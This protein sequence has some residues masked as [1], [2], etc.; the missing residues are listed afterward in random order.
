MSS[1]SWRAGLATALP[2]ALL[3]AGC[4]QWGQPQER[5]PKDAD[6]VATLSV[7][8]VSAA[9][10]ELYAK[11]LSP[12]FEIDAE[13]ALRLVGASTRQ[14]EDT[15]VRATQATFRIAPEVLTSQRSTM[16]SVD[17]TGAVSASSAASSAAGPGDLSKVSGPTFAATTLPAAIAASAPSGMNPMLQYQLANAL[18]QEVRLLNDYVSRAPRAK[19]HAP[20]VVRLQVNVLQKGRDTPYDAVTDI[21]F[22]LPDDTNCEGKNKTVRAVPLLV[23]DNV[24][25]GTAAFASHRASAVGLALAGLRGNV[26][27]GADVSRSTQQLLRSLGNQFNSVLNVGQT[28]RTNDDAKADSIRVKVG[29]MEKGLN[30]HELV[31]RSYMV[32]VLLLVPRCAQPASLRVSRLSLARDSVMANA[33]ALPAQQAASAGFAAAVKAVKD[34]SEEERSQRFATIQFSSTTFFE[35]ARTA[36]RLAA[37][38]PVSSG[39]TQ[40]CAKCKEAESTGTDRSKA[41]VDLWTWPKPRFPGPQLTRVELVEVGSGKPG[42]F[43]GKVTLRGG[44]GLV[45]NYFDRACLVAGDAMLPA[46]N[47]KACDREEAL[48][49][50]GLEVVNGRNGIQASFGPI[51]ELGSASFKATPEVVA[52]SGKGLRRFCYDYIGDLEDAKGP[53][54]S[55]CVVLQPPPPAGKA[56]SEPAF[57]AK[58]RTDDSRLIASRPGTATLTLA[59][60]WPKKKGAEPDAV[61]IQL[62]GAGVAGLRV[63]GGA[64]ACARLADVLVVTNTCLLAVDLINAAPGRLITLSAKALKADKEQSLELNPSRIEVMLRTPEPAVLLPLGKP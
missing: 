51:L 38:Q 45:S 26:G 20:Y 3:L 63:L 10:F 36:E 56:S 32:T 1:L 64:A 62:G 57:T 18:I 23:N 27:V 22:S 28:P 50:D 15:F 47:G 40:D 6:D 7:A 11:D 30:Q 35:H 34:A 39:P 58:V 41:Q 19:H 60:E 8:V 48:L 31:S 44:D 14:I 37:R 2:L 59:V 12:N 43:S 49:A 24:D 42:L 52:Y 16:S 55:V 53:T 46:Q 33:A 21:R 13:T 4:A 25:V 61:H 9:P 54:D 17:A 5:K 29:A